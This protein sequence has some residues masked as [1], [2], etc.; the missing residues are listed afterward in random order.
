MEI[1]SIKDLVKALG[2]RAKA[3]AF[4]E[5]TGSAVS[6]WRRLPD[7]YHR[8]VMLYAARRRWKLA[9]ELFDGG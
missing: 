6:Q 2:G 9:D 8:Q 3:A 1:K 5:V 7:R 4:F